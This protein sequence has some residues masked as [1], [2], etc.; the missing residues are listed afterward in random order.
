MSD[1]VGLTDVHRD[2]VQHNIFELLYSLC[3]GDENFGKL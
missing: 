2:K 1:H 3:V